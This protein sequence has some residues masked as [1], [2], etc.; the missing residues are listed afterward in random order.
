MSYGLDINK[1][2]HAKLQGFRE[3]IEG[4]IVDQA[5]KNA[6]EIGTNIIRQSGIINDVCQD[7]SPEI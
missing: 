7:T 2:T 1:G 3:L 5:D 6:Y 4:F